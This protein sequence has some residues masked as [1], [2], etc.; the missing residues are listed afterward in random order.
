MCS[1]R[2]LGEVSD[3]TRSTRSISAWAAATRSAWRSSSVEEWLRRLFLPRPPSS[4]VSVRRTPPPDFPAVGWR[5]PPSP[6]RGT[7]PGAVSVLETASPPR[8]SIMPPRSLGIATEPRVVVANCVAR[9]V[10]EKR[11]GE[12]GVSV[13]TRACAAKRLG[14]WHIRASAAE[15]VGRAALERSGLD[16]T[17]R[18]KL[19]S[20][21]SASEYSDFSL[22]SSHSS[23]CSS[24]SSS[25]W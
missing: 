13:S 8:L 7:C 2:W 4:S 24:S 22:P 17:G 5:L 9:G 14:P 21:R 10:R 11:L 1:I 18:R 16:L 19:G 15:C 20:S 25:S 23:P 12:S 6:E 3:W